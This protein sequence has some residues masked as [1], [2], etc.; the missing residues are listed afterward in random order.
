MAK[1]SDVI[2]GLQLFLSI[3]GDKHGVCAEHDEIYAGNSEATDPEKL[4]ELQ[5]QLLDQ[6][7]WFWDAEVGSWKRFV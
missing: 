4:T 2:S 1:Y 6:W 5:L 7:G 3:E